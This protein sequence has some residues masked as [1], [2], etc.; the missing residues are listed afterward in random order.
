MKVVGFLFD[1]SPYCRLTVYGRFTSPTVQTFS[2]AGKWNIACYPGVKWLFKWKNITPIHY[3]EKWQIVPET[4]W[5]LHINFMITY[6]VSGYGLDYYKSSNAI[7]VCLLAVRQR[8]LSTLIFGK[9]QNIALTFFCWQSTSQK[10]LT[11]PYCFKTSR[12]QWRVVFFVFFRRAT[13]PLSYCLHAGISQCRVRGK[14]DG[15]QQAR[16]VCQRR[17]LMQIPQSSS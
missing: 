14:E 17:Q 5:L 11:C 9:L 8:K 10:N 13:S 2:A 1:F 16:L 3:K 12:C 7:N 15:S 4:A 6:Y